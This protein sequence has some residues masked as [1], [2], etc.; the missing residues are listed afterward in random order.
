MYNLY[1]K[2][3]HYNEFD[4]KWYTFDREEQGLYM[5]DKSKMKSLKTF[6]SVEKLLN[7]Y[8]VKTEKQDA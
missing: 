8:Q 6:D 1:S 7:E 3:I 4:G 2:Y 5:N